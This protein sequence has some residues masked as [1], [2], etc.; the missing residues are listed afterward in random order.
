MLTAAGLNA[1]VQTMIINTAWSA[2]T[3]GFLSILP[4]MQFTC[5]EIYEST[6]RKESK[7]KIAP[8]GVTLMRSRV[9]YRAAP[10]KH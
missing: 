2:V 6:G 3:C 8:F 9:V 1:P 5:Q 7:E 10:G 4:F